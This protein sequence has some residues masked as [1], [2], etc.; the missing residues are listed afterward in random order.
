MTN[1]EQAME[2]RQKWLDTC[3]DYDKVKFNQSMPEHCR[4]QW[5][6]KAVDATI[7]HTN[8]LSTLTPPERHEYWEGLK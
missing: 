6:Q 2:Y 7:V 8:F 1:L 3:R 4:E 5:R